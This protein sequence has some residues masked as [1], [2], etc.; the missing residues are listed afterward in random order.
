MFQDVPE[1]DDVP[2]A[3]DQHDVP[4]IIMGGTAGAVGLNGLGLGLAG[5]SGLFAPHRDQRSAYVETIVDEEVSGAWQWGVSAYY[6]LTCP[7]QAPMDPT[8][9]VRSHRNGE[10]SDKTSS[11]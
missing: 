7:V 10:V 4:I 2:Y 8:V 1:A 5:L 11:R 3:D 6:I 9:N